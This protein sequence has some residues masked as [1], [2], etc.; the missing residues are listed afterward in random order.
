[1]T[2]YDRFWKYD[3]A[4]T[5][6]TISWCQQIA[7]ILCHEHRPIS[8]SVTS[9]LRGISLSQPILAAEGERKQQAPH[10]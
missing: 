7:A 5:T 6:L 1:M 9:C 3:Q 2:K 10:F 8:V 4:A